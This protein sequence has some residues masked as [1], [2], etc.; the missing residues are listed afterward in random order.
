MRGAIVY[1]Y[2]CLSYLC[3][4]HRVDSM[5]R[6]TSWA[7]SADKERRLLD[8]DWCIQ[9]CISAFGIRGKAGRCLPSTTRGCNWCTPIGLG[10]QPKLPTCL[11][12]RGELLASR[13]LIGSCADGYG[14]GLALGW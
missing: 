2:Y 13:D 3:T 11:F 1:Q 8:L 9:E 10:G 14:A 5:T 7:L 6:E 12:P 4:K